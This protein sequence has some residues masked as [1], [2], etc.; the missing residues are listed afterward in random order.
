VKECNIGL[1]YYRTHATNKALF[2]FFKA[3]E[4]IVVR[5]AV[6]VQQGDVRMEKVFTS[7]KLKLK[8]Y[9]SYDIRIPTSHSKT[10]VGTN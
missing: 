5:H 9:T 4:S 3:N 10:T 7:K 2:L 1:D 8:H 6:I